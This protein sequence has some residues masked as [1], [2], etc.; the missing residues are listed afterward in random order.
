M[1]VDCCMVVAPFVDLEVVVDTALD[2]G[3][4]PESEVAVQDMVPVD[5]GMV[6]A[7]QGKAPAAQ[8]MEAA[9]QDMGPVALVGVAVG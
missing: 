6:V 1:E 9:V 3:L 7:A 8:G 2:M 4:A 5:Q